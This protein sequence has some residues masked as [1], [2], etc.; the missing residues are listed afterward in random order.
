M[1]SLTLGRLVGSGVAGGFVVTLL[2]WFLFGSLIVG[3]I[4]AGIVICDSS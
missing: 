1:R 3:M 4:L 2:A